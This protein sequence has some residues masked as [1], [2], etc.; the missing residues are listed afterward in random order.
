ML[1]RTSVRQKRSYTLSRAAIVYLEH[2]RRKRKGSSASR[3]LDELIL[4]DEARQRRQAT[5]SA[6]GAYYDQLSEAER[7]EQEAWGRFALEQLKDD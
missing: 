5:E 4:E 1:R 7:R 3:V 6:I 2:L